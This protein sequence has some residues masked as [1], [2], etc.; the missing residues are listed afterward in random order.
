[1]QDVQ[2]LLAVL[3][4]RIRDKISDPEALTEVVMDSGRSLELRFGSRSKRYFSSI[5]VTDEE[6][7]QVCEQIS[8]F[9]VDNRAGIDGTLHRISCIKGRKGNILGLTCR[10]GRAFEGCVKLLQEFVDSGQS[11]LVLGAPGTGKTTKLRDIARYAS[12]ELDKSVV[13]VDTSNEIAGEGAHPHPAVGLAR[14]LMV[15]RGSSQANIMIE[16]VENHCPEIIIVDEISTEAEAT[17][18]RT[19]AQRGVQLIATAHGHKLEDLAQNPPLLDILGGVAY[20]TMGDKMMAK[21]GGAKTRPEP[22]TNPT[23]T[24]IIEL[25]G[26]DE[27]AVHPDV[28]EAFAA[29][30]RG[31][32]VTPARYRL[33]DGETVCI[34]QA[35]I[36]A[37]P[38]PEQEVYENKPFRNKLP[39][40]IEESTTRRRRKPSQPKRGRR[41]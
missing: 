23:F 7:T 8:E 11:I 40:V 6:I 41:R 35:S 28:R 25:E 36:E 4:S 16:A 38:A 15:P 30:L 32:K 3:P 37:E 21:N 29:I 10:V 31:R 9:G 1:M 22:K 13:I 2:A 34:E 18:C 26:F 24:L 12:V 20:V 39:E 27:V 33:I 17:A 5:Q 14:R 19:I